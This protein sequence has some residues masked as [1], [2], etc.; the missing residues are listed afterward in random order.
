MHV[1]QAIRWAIIA[2]K[3]VTPKAINSCFVKSTLFSLREGPLPRPYNYIDPIINK[4]QE[5]AKQLRAAGRIHEPINIQNF[6][7]LPG[8]DIVDSTED[9]IKHVAELYAGLDRDTETDEEDS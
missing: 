7:Y 6:I 3:E 1:L 9:L 2:W 8:E 4:V 5:I